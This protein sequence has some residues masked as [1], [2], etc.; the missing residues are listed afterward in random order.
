M[1]TSIL[2]LFLIVLFFGG[3]YEYYHGQIGFG[4][5]GLVGLL[6]AAVMI[7]W[8]LKANGSNGRR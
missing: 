1:G 7:V 5:L 2:L 4:A 8:L 6:L 3:G